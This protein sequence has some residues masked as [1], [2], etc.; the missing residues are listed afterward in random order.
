MSLTRVTEKYERT[1]AGT[2]NAAAKVAEYC[3]K[4]G[5]IWKAELWPN[6]QV[7]MYIIFPHQDEAKVQTWLAKMQKRIGSS[8]TGLSFEV[9]P[10][11]F[12]RI[13]VWVK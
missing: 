7:T 4:I 11:Q 5:G 2:K 12:G 9:Q 6:A 3:L 1:A 10:P 13:S 8:I